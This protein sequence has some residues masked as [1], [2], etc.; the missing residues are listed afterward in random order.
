ML[1][2]PFLRKQLR[3][4]FPRTCR[5]PGGGKERIIENCLVIDMAQN[6]FRRESAWLL[7]VSR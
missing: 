6:S 2:G 3:T 7:V 1:L 4:F 5:N